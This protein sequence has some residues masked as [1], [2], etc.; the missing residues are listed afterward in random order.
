MIAYE[1]VSIVCLA[2]FVLEVLF[3]IAE[4]FLKNRRERIAFLKNFK[5]GKCFVA[6]FTAIPLF[7]IGYLYKGEGVWYSFFSSL[8]DCVQMIVL[9]YVQ[10][11][12]KPLAE[13]CGV[14]SFAVYF[15]FTVVALNAVLFAV[16]VF[17]QK[18]AL[19]IERRLYYLGDGDR[20]V[21]YG[22]NEK[23]RLVYSSSRLKKKIL[24]GKIGGDADDLFAER[25]VFQELSPEQLLDKVIR[26]VTSAKKGKTTVIVNSGSDKENLRLAELFAKKTKELFGSNYR[27]YLKIDV[28]FFGNPRYEDVYLDLCGESGGCLHYFNKYAAI[29]KSVAERYPF[30]RFMDGMQL[31]YSTGAVRDGVDINVA[32]I[33]FG[34]TN[35]QI[36]L[37]SV[38]NNQFIKI[39]DG[40]AVL[41]RVRYEIFDREDA[42]ADK[43]L[44]H[45]YFRYKREC[46]AF[47]GD[48]LPLPSEPA[49][50]KFRKLDINE[51][52]FYD[53][54]KEIF[55]K[56]ENDANFIFVGFGDDLENIDMAKK[57][58]EKKKEWGIT[59][60]VIFVK[61][62]DKRLA[63]LVKD[64]AV[65]PIGE[66]ENVVYNVGVIGN[67]FFSKM[68]IRRN[69][70]YDMESDFASGRYG[71]EITSEEAAD[72]VAKSLDKW[73]LKK[74]ALERESSVY[75]C[76]SIRSKLNLLG[77]DYVKGGEGITE[78]EYYGIYAENDELDFERYGVSVVG[79]K[80]VGYGPK[81]KT[82]T[83]RYYMAELE[84]FRWNSF[85]LSKGVIPADKK[86]ILEEKIEKEGKI[87]FT[88]GKNYDLRRHGNLTTF[89]GL[90]EF[91]R[92]I[93]ERD[94]V[95]ET[96][97][98]VIK[99]DYQ[100][101]DD[102][103]WFLTESG[104]SIVKKS[105][106][107]PEKTNV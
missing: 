19:V 97:T 39:V 7:F 100:I 30:S 93:A 26:I 37:T 22:N 78:D 8:S 52:G 105:K 76:L 15:C 73:Y 50:I 11:G 103:F 47:N 32:M 89:E 1:V 86:T 57:I 24:V 45:S 58:V 36:F 80:I 60:L 13:V 56:G 42:S 106:K 64:E 2:A 74:S 68:A 9:K 33:G 77:L 17:G 83:K 94:G 98:D 66:E 23:N 88:N 10:T 91:S 6:L 61:I 25:V 12:V 41:K 69:A 87:K 75:G 44:N 71:S 102:A 16:S 82:G 101:L 104:Y 34:S 95:S 4:L 49:D 35:R 63:S 51:Y 27:L 84:H 65:Y 48:Y 46:S 5:K 92:L 107:L 70:A 3:V 18:V 67:D 90:K 20:L 14:Y 99:Y 40:E 43:N 96:E 59:R 54:L 85:M 79:K 81:Y 72:S 55:T 62:R 29:A 28:Y 38:A 21:V 31:D 53:G